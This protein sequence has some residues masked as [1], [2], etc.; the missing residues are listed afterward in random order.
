M[1]STSHL[2]KYA[3]PIHRRI[4][5]HNTDFTCSG[6]VRNK[7]VATQIR[8]GERVMELFRDT[9]TEDEFFGRQICDYQ[10]ENIVGESRNIHF[11]VVDK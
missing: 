7:H 11:E 3:C 6:V 8:L 4:L 2:R 10:E 1:I 9:A 5:I